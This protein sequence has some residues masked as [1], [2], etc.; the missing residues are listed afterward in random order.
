MVVV[1]PWSRLAHSCQSL[2]RFWTMKRLGV[3]L[4]LD[5]MLVH[6]KSLPCNVLGFPNNSQ[7]PIYTA[8]WREALWESSV[9]PKNT[10]QYPQ[11]GLEPGPLASGTSALTIRPL[12]LPDC[13]SQSAIANIS[14][15][16]PSWLIWW[17]PWQLWFG[18]LLGRQCQP[19]FPYLVTPDASR[20]VERHFHKP[21]LECFG[22]NWCPQLWQTQCKIELICCLTW[23]MEKKIALEPGTLAS[24][25]ALSD[26][27]KLY[28]FNI[29]FH[30]LALHS[31]S[32][33]VNK[34][35]VTLQS[36]WY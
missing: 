36:L 27:S 32:G 29:Y 8:G 6:R 10:S 7:V 15:A 2:S 1:K 12:R 30:P 17:Y 13:A 23:K 35:L 25:V 24:S 5:E 3:F 19:R 34:L 18:T 28:Q 33:M 26:T 11:P 31:P 21:P 22:I 16:S 4:L 9:L 20:T 14:M